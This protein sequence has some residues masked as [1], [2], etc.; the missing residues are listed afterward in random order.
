MFERFE[1]PLDG[2]TPVEPFD[3]SHPAFRDALVARYRHH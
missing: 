1:R 2:V 3:P